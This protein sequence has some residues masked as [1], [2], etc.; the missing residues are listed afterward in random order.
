[1]KKT[2]KL[3]S[4]LIS[5]CFI[6]TALSGCS[7]RKKGDPPVWTKDKR[8]VMT[9][10]DYNVKYD[11]YRYLFLNSKSYYDNGDESYWQKDGNNVEKVKEYVLG[12]LKKTYAM[13]TL[14]D[15]YEI[16][17]SDLDKEDVK[18]YI[19]ASKEGYSDEAYLQSLED[20]YMTEDL[21]RFALEI[22][23]LEYLVYQHVIDESNGV[24]KVD[25]SAVSKSVKED[26]V[27]ASH[28]L[29][30]YKNEAESKTALDEANKILERLKN[31]EDFETLKEAYSDDT[32]LKGNKD[33]Y[34]FTKGEFGNEFEYTA[35]ELKENEISEIVKTEIGYHIIKRLPIEEEYV[36]SHFEELRTQYKTAL[37]YEMV[38][39]TAD[40][41]SYSYKDDYKDIQLDSFK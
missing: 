25:D 32:D 29:F 12:S 14:A 22:Q 36:N 30:T 20:S 8:I 40:T 1:M 26:F 21:Y 16:T 3:F 9:L 5:V 34:Y 27:R 6:L 38:D 4:F 28:I 17:L 2:L 10:G 33:G 11:F 18:S 24:L 15:K 41:L 19:E 37:Y 7:G 35:F 39:E 23:Q 31:G 13:F